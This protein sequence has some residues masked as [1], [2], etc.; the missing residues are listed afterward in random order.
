VRSTIVVESISVHTDSNIHRAASPIAWA[1]QSNGAA[2][3]L[4]AA[5]P[6]VSQTSAITGTLHTPTAQTAWPTFQKKFTSATDAPQMTA[7]PSATRTPNLPR[8]AR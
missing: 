1:S 3:K 8:P 5:S 6:A 2:T 4:P 7:A